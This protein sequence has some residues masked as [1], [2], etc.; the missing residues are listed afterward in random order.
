MEVLIAIFIMVAG[1]MAITA[2]Y[3][4]SLK[5]SFENRDQIIAAGLAQEGVELIRNKRDTNVLRGVD[6]FESISSVCNI[7][8]KT[9]T[10]GTGA[11]G[12]QY[13]NN[14]YERTGSSG[15]FHR[16]IETSQA[17]EL[18][19]VMSFVSWDSRTPEQVSDCTSVN[20]CTYAQI[21][22]SRWQ[23]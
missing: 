9:L 16:R 2:L 5:R 17:G 8:H 4:R 19:T 18:L 13:A 3:S 6:S 22:L 11:T 1:L 21:Q 10:C 7:D 20:A 14:F 23:E 12:L 15:R